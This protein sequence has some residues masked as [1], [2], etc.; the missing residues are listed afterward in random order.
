MNTARA[1]GFAAARSTPPSALS[2]PPRP[3]ATQARAGFLAAADLMASALS[4]KPAARAV[5]IA[6][7][8][9]LGDQLPPAGNPVRRGADAA[10]GR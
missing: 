6:G 5:F 3:R 9:G 4:C 10:A 7:R 2:R 8:G 1:A